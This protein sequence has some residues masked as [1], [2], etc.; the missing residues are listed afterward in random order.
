[1]NYNTWL[2]MNG[3]LRLKT[4]VTVKERNVEMLFDQGQFWENVD[5]SQTKAYAMGLGEVYLNVKGREAQGIVNPGPEYDALKQELK[6]KLVA[7]QDP[8]DG[9]YPVRRVLAREEIYKQFDPNMI[10]DLFALNNDGY[11][12][13]WQTAL[14]GIPKTL[15][16]TNNAT[17][18]GDHCSVDPEIV[19]GIFFMNRKLST[20]RAP[21]IADIYPTVLGVLGV[22][23]PYA[24]DGVELK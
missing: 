4:G 2:V 19:K 8:E 23:A 3:Y 13:S 22:K 18:S 15:I 12:V 5:W 21:Y 17:W 1:V 6:T 14:G 11:R 20:S 24:L 9:A 10:P 16:D 7:M